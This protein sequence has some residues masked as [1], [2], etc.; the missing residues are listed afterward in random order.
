[1]LRDRSDHPVLVLFARSD[2]SDVR[3]LDPQRV[4]SCFC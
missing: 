2:Q 3:V 4:H 1:M